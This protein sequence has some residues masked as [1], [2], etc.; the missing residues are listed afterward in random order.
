MNS[1]F[2]WILSLRLYIPLL[3]SEEVTQLVCLVES[4]S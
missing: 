3:P 1:K 4:S 2:L